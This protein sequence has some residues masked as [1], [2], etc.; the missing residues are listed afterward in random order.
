MK[1]DS[2]RINKSFNFYNLVNVNQEDME[3]LNIT[4]NFKENTLVIKNLPKIKFQAQEDS[5]VT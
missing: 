1:P 5:L 3:H 2:R 4:I